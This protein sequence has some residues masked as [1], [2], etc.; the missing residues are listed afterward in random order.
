MSRKRSP[1]RPRQSSARRWASL[2]QA[3][4]ETHRFLKTV[5]NV[6]LAVHHARHDHVKTVGTEIHRGHGLRSRR[7]AHRRGNRG[8]KPQRPR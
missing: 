3:G 1:K 6:E 5:H 2:V 4:A 7:A 8:H